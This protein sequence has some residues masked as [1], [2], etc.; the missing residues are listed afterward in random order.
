MK[1]TIH[2]VLLSFSLVSAGFADARGTEWGMSMEQV[3]RIEEA[4]HQET[5]CDGS[6]CLS[7]KKKIENLDSTITYRFDQEERL[8]QIDYRFRSNTSEKD[9][10]YGQVR[11]TLVSRYVQPKVQ[12]VGGKMTIVE[13]ERGDTKIRLSARFS[14]SHV[15]VS[16]FHMAMQEDF[17]RFKVF[18]PPDDSESDGPRLRIHI[19]E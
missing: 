11:K 7:Y 10:T 12:I 6:P 13:W 14:A 5:V 3:K 8:Y 4:K 16:H 2:F 18:G 17:K 1:R 19:H 15:S 9:G